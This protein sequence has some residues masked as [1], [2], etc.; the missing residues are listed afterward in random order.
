MQYSNF[1]Y[2]LNSQLIWMET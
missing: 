2:K 1:A